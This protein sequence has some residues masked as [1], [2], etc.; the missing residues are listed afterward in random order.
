[1]TPPPTIVLPD[2]D[3][4]MAAVLSRPGFAGRLD[5]LGGAAVHADVP[6]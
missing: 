6:S 5:R 3:P 1:M 4:H 2:G